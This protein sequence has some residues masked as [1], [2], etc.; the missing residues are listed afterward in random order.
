MPEILR[1]KSITQ[2]HALMGMETAGHPLVS[3][4]THT[5]EMVQAYSRIKVVADFYSISLKQGISGAFTYGRSAYDFEDGTLVFTAPDQVVAAPE[6]P[7]G[8]SEQEGWTLIFHPDL[9]RRHPLGAAISTYSFFDYE[10]NEALHVSDK[11]KG[12]LLG[13]IRTIEDEIRQNM[14]R[15]TQTLIV[16]NIQLLLNY[17]ARYYDRQFYT[18][19]DLSHDVVIRFQEMLSGYFQDRDQLELGLPS[20]KYCAERLHLSPNYLSDLLKK[21]TGRTAQDHIHAFVIDR[22]KT[23]LLNTN[24]TVSEIAFDLGFDYS[25]HFSRLFKTRTGMSPT[26]YR[27]NN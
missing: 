12:I 3:V 26:T 2:I 20:V 5:P 15:H 19:S 6:S 14:D 23:R 8:H 7:E 13:L 22:A 4:F 10:V 18:R 21:E 9:I 27:R 1:I 11:E 17:C 24:E 16:S 25:Q